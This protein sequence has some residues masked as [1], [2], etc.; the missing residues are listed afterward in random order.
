MRMRVRAKNPQ[1]GRKIEQVEEETR[2]ED[3]DERGQ[4]PPRPQIMTPPSAPVRAA[5]LM[6][7]DATEIANG[8]PPIPREDLVVRGAEK[9]EANT[10]PFTNPKPRSRMILK[11]TKA[12]GELAQRVRVKNL[13]EK[14]PP[15]RIPELKLARAHMTPQAVKRLEAALTG[16]SE[17]R[18]P[19]TANTSP[20]RSIERLINDDGWTK[21]T[22]ELRAQ[23]LE[24]I[25]QKPSDIVT[26]NATLKLVQAEVLTEC[27]PQESRRLVEAFAAMENRERKDLAT[28]AARSL[29]GR[30]ALL[31]RDIEDTP[32][33]EHIAAL[34]KARQLAKPLEAAG[35]QK[36][37]AISAILS[38]LAAPARLPL[39]DRGDGVLGLLEFG[40]ADSTP[41]ELVRMWRGLCT[42]DM[43]AGL[44]NEGSLDLSEALRTQPG[45]TMS[46]TN[47]PLR[48][49]LEQ[50]V[51]LAHPR[52][53]PQRGALVMP[54]SDCLDA[55]V[56]A[57]TVGFL[58]GVGFTVASGGPG[59]MRHL[60]NLDD[61]PQRVPPVFVTLLHDHGE[62]MFVF[63][64]LSGGDV[65]VRSPH[66]GSSKPKGGRRL[67]PVRAVVDPSRGVDVIP[68]ADFEA[69][70]GVALIPRT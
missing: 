67:N 70:V 24:V 4:P 11:G 12:A 58:Y 62:R 23:L 2:L 31:D 30:S 66:G 9:P 59:A 40:L 57:R 48:V 43:V 37:H 19:N 42:K 65:C 25:G 28:L 13:E 49:A 50:L 55:D 10:E 15:T 54:G 29:H 52:A 69:A 7:D 32:I 26:V 18:G 34:V 5:G 61:A 53:G 63:D 35:F 14:L 17:Q 39:E 44:P 51:G 1:I 36:R 60:Q 64:R 6:D 33:G 45:L 8:P 46:G 47:T 68:R 38:A 27:A 16:R 3:S 20:K 22:L 21:M 56:I 41:A